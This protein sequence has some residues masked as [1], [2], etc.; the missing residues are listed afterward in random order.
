MIV[1]WD[2]FTA[3]PLLCLSKI[4]FNWIVRFTAY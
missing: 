1:S 4:D 2:G 3:F